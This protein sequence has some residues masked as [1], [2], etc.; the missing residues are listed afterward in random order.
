[1]ETSMN[2]TITNENN[3][4]IFRLL[5]LDDNTTFKP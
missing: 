5:G 3:F 1:V 2:I 4:F